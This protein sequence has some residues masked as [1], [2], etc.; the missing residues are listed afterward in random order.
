MSTLSDFF[1]GN[2]KIGINGTGKQVV[3]AMCSFNTTQGSGGFVFFDE[4]FRVL[5][6]QQYPDTNNS[7]AGNSSSPS[8]LYMGQLNQQ[9]YNQV[10]YNINSTS[11]YPSSNSTQY[12]LNSTNCSGEFGNSG[13][14]LYSDG[15]YD[16]AYGMTNQQGNK[17]YLNAYAI[18]SDHL[19]KRNAYILLNGVIRCVDRLNPNYNYAKIGT[20]D[21]TVTSLNTSM[22][23]SASYNRARKEMV[24]LSYASSGGNFNVITY[25]NLDLDANEDPSVAFAAATRVN[26]TVAFSTSW[27]AN[28]SESYY[29]LKPILC[30]GG[31]VYTS[32]MFTSNAQRLYSFT[33]SG[34]SAVTAT[35]VDSN[36]LTTSYG[37]D[38]AFQYGQR[39]ITSRDGTS[40]AV[41]CP[42]YY[43]GA[44]IGSFMVNKTTANYTKYLNTD[45]GY[46]NQILPYKDN[47]WT[48]IY[49]GNG[50]AGNYTGN[51]IMATYLSN[52]SATAGSA[53]TQ[54]GTTRYFPMHTY[55]NTTNYPGFTQ[56][57]DYNS[58]VKS[59][60]GFK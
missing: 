56:V 15:T 7:N 28:N 38:Q 53:F 2:N 19:N 49:C 55:P 59:A 35:L 57:T 23:G 18:N 50:Y 33:R 20:T 1:G 48:Y 29:N 37:L 13:V 12:W 60:R 6:A 24:I 54:I 4:D 39:Q 8:G 47:G 22:Q 32:V 42:Y 43:Y 11:T 36:S 16:S 52:G 9:Y 21:F 26:S 44:G 58:L 41:F 46:G 3:Y 14:F 10:F 34:T 5:N 45:T 31:L 40:V 51:W 27:S 25:T 30:A 17:H